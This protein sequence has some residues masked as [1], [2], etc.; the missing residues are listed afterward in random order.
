M[1]FGCFEGVEYR[2]NALPVAKAASTEMT[3]LVSLL[4]KAIFQTQS[5]EQP[6]PQKCT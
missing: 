3:R 2:G 1:S 5:Q 4:R 6:K